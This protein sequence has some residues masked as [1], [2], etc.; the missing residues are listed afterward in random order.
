MMNIILKKHMIL[1]LRWI[2][3]RATRTRTVPQ[4]WDP[5]DDAFAA[6]EQIV[7]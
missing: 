3:S 2:L 7:T 4:N 5:I 6:T 1:L